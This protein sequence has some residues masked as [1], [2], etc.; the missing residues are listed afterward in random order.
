MRVRKEING[1]PYYCYYLKA[2]TAL[3][4]EVRITRTNPETQQEEPYIFSATDLKPTPSL[5]STSGVQAA[6]QSKV[7]VTYRMQLELLGSELLEVINI[8]FD[9]DQRRA[10]ISEY[11]LYS[12]E[13]QI[14]QG[15]DAD[16]HAF[17]YTEAIYAQMCYK[18][19][20]IGN[21]LTTEADSIRR[22][23]MFGDG[24]LILV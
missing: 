22:T 6:T 8:M 9:G 5:P 13:D 1:V 15:F 12:G 23:Y 17:N 11:G 24:N 4:T 7:N 3:D 20:N 19:C 16:N 2:L 18:I 21:S 10:K 14:V